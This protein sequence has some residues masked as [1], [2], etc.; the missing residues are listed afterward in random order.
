MTGN[1]LLGASLIGAAFVTTPVALAGCFSVGGAGLARFNI[2]ASTLRAAATPPAFRS[3]MA[4]GV[5]FLSSSLNPFAAQGMGLMVDRI[6]ATKGVFL[7]GALILAATVLLL[8]NRDAKALL[9][10]PSEDIVGAYASLYP[11]A[12]I[13]RGAGAGRPAA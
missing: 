7:S 9:I 5:A 3:R 10:R 8:R 1:G 6:G 4:A 12:F 13:T 11:R 2:N